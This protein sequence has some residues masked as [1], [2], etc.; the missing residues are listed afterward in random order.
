ME[1][2]VPGDKSITQRALI[3]ASLAD[4]ESRLR[5][6]LPSADPKATAGA[7]R[8]L[9]ARVPD[10]PDDGSEIRVRGAGLKG[11]EA[12]SAPVHLG[13]SGT[14]ARL[15]MGV[16]AAQPFDVV[17]TGDASLRSRPMRRVT[18]PLERMGA[19]FEELG[20]ADRLPIRVRGGTLRPAEYE[21]PVARAQVK[22]ALLLAGLA[23]GV[24]VLVSEPDRSRDHT[25]R[26]LALC[27]SPTVDHWNRGRW[28]VE[29]RDPPERI[30]PL[31]LD[32]PG[33]FSSAAFLLALGLL[34]GAG[35]ELVVK[36][37]GLN[38]T[39]TG[40]LPVLE[41]MGGRLE[42]EGSTEGEGEPSG[43]LA[44][45][46]A[47][48]RSIDLGEDEVVGVIDEIPLIAVLAARAEG[49]TRITGAGELRV[50][51]TD[52]I[53]A[54]VQNFRALG[55]DVEELD[56]G[57]VI[58][59]SPDPLRGAVRAYDDHRI[60][61]AF[62]VLGAAPGNEIR[63]DE[64]GVVDVSFPEFWQILERA[65]GGGDP[66]KAERVD[67]DTASV[68]S[69]RPRAEPVVTVDGPAGSGKSSTARAVAARLGFRHLDSGALYRAL[70][71]ALLERD[72]PVERWGDLGPGELQEIPLELRPADDSFRVLYDGRPLTD[73]L[74]SDTVTEHVSRAASAGAVRSRLL[75][76]Q[77]EAARLGPL[78]ADGRDM[79]T[80]VF[81]DADVKIFLTAKLEER[82]RRRLKER[83]DREPEPAAITAEV[84][85]IAERDRRD[86][87]RTLSPLRRPED[88]VVLDTT[89]LSFEEQVRA[90]VERIETLTRP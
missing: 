45:R 84:D 86:S 14:G 65:A 75:E 20:E 77:R 83:T 80:V 35:P 30:R 32:V 43:A 33:D 24:F 76:L 40:L 47:S 2:T 52:R 27:G 82:A 44:V 9:G 70:T 39:R 41:R 49:I 48:L 57:L 26:M 29:L 19:R 11:L 51:E 85:R 59:G 31:D 56:D 3:L 55:V 37:V 60:A 23:G 16:L 87:E 62:A 36:D 4:G 42:V 38:P 17:V 18:G 8:A 71:F 90:V 5:G 6:L 68:G 61:M 12:P 69:T 64:P 72:V 46:P 53:H 10:L 78:V 79:G 22:S 66:A 54:L 7:L 81:P 89:D 34:G 15:L 21:T 67:S 58:E 25:E 13:N 88:A 1:L 73:E 63:I 28:R 50:K 74:R